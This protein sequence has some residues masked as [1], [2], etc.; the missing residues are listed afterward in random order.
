M[1]WG[2]EILRKVQ[3]H[4]PFLDMLYMVGGSAVPLG[5]LSPRKWSGKKVCA[6]DAVVLVFGPEFYNVIS[7]R[8]TGSWTYE[9]VKFPSAISLVRDDV[10]LPLGEPWK[11]NSHLMR[12]TGL[13]K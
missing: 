6:T 10:V 2:L 3:C 5:G 13:I 4:L 8:A 9:M 7:T 1:G 12:C 11:F